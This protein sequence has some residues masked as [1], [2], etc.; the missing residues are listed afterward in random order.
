MARPDDPLVSKLEFDIS[1]MVAG[2]NFISRPC[3]AASFQEKR[4]FEMLKKQNGL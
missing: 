2:E 3:S 4:K 1:P